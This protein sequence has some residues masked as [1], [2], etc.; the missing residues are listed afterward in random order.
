[1]AY[2]LVGTNTVR[3]LSDGANIPFDPSNSAYAEYQEWLEAGNVPEPET[4]P[5]RSKRRISIET[6]VDR[7]TEAELQQLIAAKDA[8][9]VKRRMQ[10]DYAMNNSLPAEHPM[11][12]QMFRQ[13]Y[14]DARAAELLAP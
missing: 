8:A 13:L 3:R 2:R 5:D 14:G 9:P 11:I 1:M 6:I 10:F 7:A 12:R 4:T